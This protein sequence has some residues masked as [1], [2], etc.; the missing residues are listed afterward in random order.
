MIKKEFDENVS[1]I[2]NLNE[3]IWN[4]YFLNM[5]GKENACKL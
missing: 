1:S 5:Y 4:R 3:F 2:S